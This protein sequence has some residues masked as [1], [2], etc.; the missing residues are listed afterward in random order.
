MLTFVERESSACPGSD[1]YRV[2]GHRGGNKSGVLGVLWVQFVFTPASVKQHF[3]VMQV[4]AWLM[5]LKPYGP[6]QQDPLDLN[7]ECDY[8][9]EAFSV[10]VYDTISSASFC[11]VPLVQVGGC[12]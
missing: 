7:L 3:Q 2:L 6:K 12:A 9:I 5:M 10:L 11:T 8:T 4:E 1:L